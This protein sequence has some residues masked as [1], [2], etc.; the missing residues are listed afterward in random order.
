LSFSGAI[1]VAM[2]KGTLITQEM[3]VDFLEHMR[4]G[5]TRPEAAKLVGSTGSRFRSLCNPDSVN[6]DERFT[7]IYNEVMAAGGEHEQ[8]RLELI[9]S[10]V[11]RR[12]MEGEVRLLE[13]LSI[14]Y[15]PDWAFFRN[16][17]V[18]VQGSLDSF[19]Q[20]HFSHLSSGQLET[21]LE[22]VEQR[23]VTPA[24]LELVANEGE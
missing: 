8:N 22:W 9:R 13:K 21:L 16:Q 23:S 4:S 5:L 20:A 18:E 3:K 11:M 14:V 6:Y 7:R 19:V 2:P 24:P 17:R 10:E 12:A 15:D 1:I